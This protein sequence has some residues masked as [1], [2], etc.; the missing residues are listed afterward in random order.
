MLAVGR[1]LGPYELL[2]PLGE[3]GMGQVWRA[4]D[5][6]LGREVALKVLP[7]AFA[8]DPERLRRFQQEARTLA[9]ITHPNLVQVFEAGEWEG[10]PYLVMELLEGETLRER[11]H[12]KPMPPKRAAEL[13]REV[14]QGLAAAHEKG[15]LHRDLKP[16]NLFI[17]RDGRVKVLDFGLAKVQPLSADSRVETADFTAAQSE[18]GQVLG[19]PGYLSPEQVRGGPVDARSDLFSLGVVLWEMVAGGRPFQGDSVIEVMHAILKE[20]PPGLPEALKVPPALAGILH[21][22]LTKAPEGRF[23]SAFDLAF[24]LQAVLDAA[25]STRWAE[26]PLPGRGGGRPALRQLWPLAAVGLAA[27][28]LAAALAWHSWGQE[29]VRRPSVV[30]LPTKVLGSQ[31]SAFLADAIPDTL[32]TLLASAEGIETKCPPSSVELEKVK[33][34]TAKVAEAYGVDLLLVTTVTV[35]GDKLFLNAQLVEAPT[36]KVRWGSQLEGTRGTYNDLIRQAAV[37]VVRAM[38]P[39]G[40]RPS[41]IAGPAFSSEIELALREGKY[42]E[43]RYTFTWKEE[44]FE[45]ALAALQRAQSLDPTSATLAAELAMLFSEKDVRARDLQSHQQARAWATRALELDPRCGLA[46]TVCCLNE[47]HTVGKADPD[48]L[49]EY[50]LKA[51]ALSPGD[52]RVHLT[53]GV[54]APT[55]EIQVATGLHVMD[56]DPLDEGG[57]LNAAFGLID[58]GRPAEAIPILERAQRLNPDLRDIK[59][60]LCRALFKL[61]RNEEALKTWVPFGWGAGILR[62]LLNR[63]QGA[64]R[65]RSLKVVAS[66]REEEATAWYWA[67][68]AGVVGPFLVR[69]GLKEEALWVLEKAAE[70]KGPMGLD[71]AVMDPDLR[72][73]KGDPRYHRALE[74]YRENALCFLK[75]AEA[76]EAQGNL[77][78][79]LKP[80]LA[81]LR[82]LVKRPI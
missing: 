5:T 48:K 76:A 15:I 27:L 51:V 72:Q 68:R 13:A 55:A 21:R 61:G 62:D 24:A 74:V 28:G 32:S 7:E 18:P 70:S 64:A 80:S 82:E 71:V 34:D 6:R 49:A 57:Y 47:V 3:G 10:A 40:A 65:E 79:Y 41:V 59:Y 22:C 45:S 67:C 20:E 31:E 78:A 17:T 36:R 42:L 52:A 25:G 56:L 60:G 39:P 1:C 50:A 43:R 30:A 9:A 12:G 35:Q 58:T 73:L 14:A 77:P 16:E 4:L 69:V 2:A 37:G 44:Y 19:T 33:G 53:L 29:P 8:S 46:W 11:M 23:H 26:F 54:M 63:D 75:H 81:E 66:W 38:R